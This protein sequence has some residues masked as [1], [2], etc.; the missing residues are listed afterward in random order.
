MRRGRICARLHETEAERARLKAELTRLRKEN[1][2]A[3]AEMEA[4]QKIVE[5]D[6]NEA[7]RQLE[8]LLAS[9]SWRLTAPLRASVRLARAIGDRLPFRRGS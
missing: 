6:L 4:R 2:Q 9:R 3:L 1:R 7:I 5:N 8:A